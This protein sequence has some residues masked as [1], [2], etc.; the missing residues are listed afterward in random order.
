MP[1][2]P[3][4][5]SMGASMTTEKQQEAN[6][7]NAL[8][9][10]G[11]RTPKGK[12][13]VARNAVTHGLTGAA[14]V[15]AGIEREEDWQ[16]FRDG[17]ISYLAPQGCLE[18]A[19][20]ERVALSF[21]RLQRVAR[22]ETGVINIGQEEIDGKLKGIREEMKK[23]SEL[24][25]LAKS[26]GEESK[27]KISFFKSFTKRAD[28]EM[29]GGTRAYDVFEMASNATGSRPAPAADFAKAIV[30][31]PEAH[32]DPWNWEGWTVGFVRQ[33]VIWLR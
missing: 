24:R 5:F 26:R 19:L 32:K 30:L 1:F 13:I 21:W 33:L 11:P 25:D 7:N 28:Y 4:Y 23:V 29:V 31:P 15:I 10:T 16:D 9:S 14:P 12:A 17:V 27:Q 18:Q 6:K 3:R 20:A 22:Y 2:C 8:G